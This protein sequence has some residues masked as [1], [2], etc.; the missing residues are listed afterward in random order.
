MDHRT[1]LYQDPEG[2]VANVQRPCPR[3]KLISDD[4]RPFLEYGVVFH[5][6]SKLVFAEQAVKDRKNVLHRLPSVT[7]VQLRPA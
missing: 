7:G 2:A 5:S 1:A 6:A 4:L 3:S